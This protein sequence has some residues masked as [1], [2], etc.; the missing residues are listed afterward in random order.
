MSKR[1]QHTSKGLDDV[2]E[3]NSKLYSFRDLFYIDFNHGFI[4]LWFVCIG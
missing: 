4:G 1:A 3:Q 2:W